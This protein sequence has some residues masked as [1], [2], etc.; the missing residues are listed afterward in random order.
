MKTEIQ[1][2]FQPARGFYGASACETQRAQ[3]YAGPVQ[4]QKRKQRGPRGPVLAGLPG[5][6]CHNITVPETSTQATHLMNPQKSFTC[7]NFKSQTLNW[8]IRLFA[9]FNLWFRA[10]R[11][12]AVAYGAVALAIAS[13]SYLTLAQAKAEFARLGLGEEPLNPRGTFLHATASLAPWFHDGTVDYGQDNP[14]PPTIVDLAS[15][16]IA[17]GDT[18]E[19]SIS[20]KIAYFTGQ[21]PQEPFSVL[22]LFSSSQV[23]LGQAELNRVPGAI[24]TGVAPHVTMNT[25][26]G[27]EPTDIA[28]DF[29][30][31]PANGYRIRV[32]AGAK[33]LFLAVEDSYW[34][35]NSGVLF[36]A[37]GHPQLEVTIDS[38]NFEVPVGESSTPRGLIVCNKGTAPI[39]IAFVRDCPP[40]FTVYG[41]EIPIA[42][43]PDECFLGYE[44]VFR[45]QQTG[46][47]TCTLTFST[48]DDT[49]NNEVQ[50]QLNGTGTT[51][52]QQAIENL[53]SLINGFVNTGHLNAGQGDALL[54]TLSA[55]FAQLDKGN[56]SAA[57]NQLNAFQKQLN[58]LVSAGKLSFTQAAELL[59]DAQKVINQINR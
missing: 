43:G 4:A 26:F 54:A 14:E 9:A 53:K 47:S 55:A 38:E 32:P 45:P 46:Q 37:G 49:T 29:Q 27:D 59:S 17:P 35:D 7:F 56:A 16:G 22:G 57:I 40:E 31:A 15:L 12:F 6:L 44:V 3:K 21:T 33:Y 24:A 41:D 39:R 36:A 34:G 42:L 11:H 5:Q 1:R 28:E 58:A 48:D 18:L 20:G 19:I 2:P 23:L 51:T 50:V 25:L 30:I 13:A 8:P 52:A 10:V